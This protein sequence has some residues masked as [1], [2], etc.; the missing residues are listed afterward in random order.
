LTE[1]F[2]NEDNDQGMRLAWRKMVPEPVFAAVPPFTWVAQPLGWRPATFFFYIVP[3]ACAETARSR[4]KM[5]Q[6]HRGTSMLQASPE[7]DIRHPAP[8]FPP[9][10]LM[11]RQTF[12]GQAAALAAARSK[13][14]FPHPR[15]AISHPCGQTTFQRLCCCTT[16]QALLQYIL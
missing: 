7:G 6:Q 16:A 10:M 12:R 4:P 13:P 15:V 5:W 11:R 8:P 9:A 2:I 3:Q 1:C 14:S